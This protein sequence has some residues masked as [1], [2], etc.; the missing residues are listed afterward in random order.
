MKRRGILKVTPE[1]I[2]QALELKDGIEIVGC[3]WSDEADDM[4]L[5]KLSGESLPVVHEGAWLPEVN[6]EDVAKTSV[7]SESEVPA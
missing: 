2:A 6:I 1:L 5:L 4:I 7:I 3:R